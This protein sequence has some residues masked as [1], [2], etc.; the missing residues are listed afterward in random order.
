MKKNLWMIVFI[1]VSFIVFTPSEVFAKKE[2][3]PF[4]W[5]WDGT[6]S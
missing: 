2:K 1:L 5:E 4:K 6:K 3:K